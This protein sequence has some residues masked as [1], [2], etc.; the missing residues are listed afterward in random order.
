MCVREHVAYFMPPLHKSVSP[1]CGHV[2][3]LESQE[4]GQG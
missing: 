2:P 4:G 1:Q 3:V